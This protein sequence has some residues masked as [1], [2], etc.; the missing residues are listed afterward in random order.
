V[1]STLLC[2]SEL[3]VEVEPDVASMTLGSTATVSPT[4]D[5]V[6]ACS[7]APAQELLIVDAADI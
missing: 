1:V 3:Q 7:S 2:L 6:F 4:D 5:E